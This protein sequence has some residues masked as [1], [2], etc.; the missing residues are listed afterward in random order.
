MHGVSATCLTLET[1]Q[2]GG[3]HHLAFP[4]PVGHRLTGASS[5]SM[6]PR[7]QCKG[8]L[9]NLKILPIPDFVRMIYYEL[10]R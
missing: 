3:T 4:T 9:N 5:V 2:R 8:F 10:Y 7:V 6:L 1:L